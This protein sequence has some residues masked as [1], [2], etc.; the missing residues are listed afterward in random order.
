MPIVLGTSLA[1]L[2]YSELRIIERKVT[3]VDMK[4]IA[5]VVAFYVVVSGG[6]LYRNND[7]ENLTGELIFLSWL[8]WLGYIDW[9]E[10]IIPKEYMWVA[11]PL[12]GMKYFVLNNGPLT[13]QEFLLLVVMGGVGIVL[14]RLIAKGD[15]IMSVFV[16]IFQGMGQ[17]AAIFMVA[18]CSVCL[19][20]LILCIVRDIR[21]R[22]SLKMAFVPF[23]GVGF[24]LV[25]LFN[26]GGL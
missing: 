3:W 20:S 8:C 21:L 14:K 23:L 24:G 10:G 6:I 2:M 19:Y 22:P 1:L 26:S 13:A 11:L 4:Q 12:I 9:K 15:V 17:G 18:L 16:M 25:L 5:W 7:Y